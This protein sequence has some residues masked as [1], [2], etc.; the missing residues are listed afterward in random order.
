M[1]YLLILIISNFA[2][3]MTFGN[4]GLLPVCLFANYLLLRR[5]ITFNKKQL[6]LLPKLLPHLIIGVLLTVMQFSR[7]HDYY[8][9]IVS[10]FHLRGIEN[11]TAF[12]AVSV[13]HH[14]D[15]WCMA[16]LMK[17]SSF[18]SINADHVNFYS[19]A[20]LFI[21]A[22]LSFRIWSV[23]FKGRTLNYIL[24][25]AV[26]LLV[27]SF[28][29]KLTWFIDFELNGTKQSILFLFLF[30]LITTK[31]KDLRKLYFLAF[32]S[33]NPL[34]SSWFTAL[35]SGAYVLSYFLR[36]NILEFK[37]N[38]PILGNVIL[39][40][41]IFWIFFIVRA[42]IFKTDFPF[43]P[44]GV[45]YTTLLP[46]SIKGVPS[47]VLFY[48]RY[49]HN[50]LYLRLIVFV[51][52]SLHF[53]LRPQQRR[54][55]LTIFIYLGFDFVQAG[56]FGYKFFEFQ[57]FTAIPLSIVIIFLLG[58]LLY[59]QKFKELMKASFWRPVPIHQEGQIL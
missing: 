22:L 3:F 18:F 14:F 49:N 57:Q 26:L 47:T 16:L 1:S 45:P 7:D 23:L 38:L 50:E 32:L 40:S 44:G 46:E 24:F 52:A 51:F 6:L 35:L 42:F 19:I 21:V 15:L 5:E 37:R 30:E 17:V 54:L 59:T 13:Y 41:A 33:C 29:S 53:L 56:Y 27:N 11:N 39:L 20:N 12:T 8:Y 4:S 2:V 55:S 43:V 58:D 48:Y 36:W 28:L 9:N 10:A 31:N 25:L 34:I